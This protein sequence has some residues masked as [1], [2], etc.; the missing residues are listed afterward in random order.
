M[1][2]KPWYFGIEQDRNPIPM[3]EDEKRIEKLI[4][5]LKQKGYSDSAIDFMVCSLTDSCFAEQD[6]VI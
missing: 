3:S 6:H 5:D 1:V 4:Y 2:R